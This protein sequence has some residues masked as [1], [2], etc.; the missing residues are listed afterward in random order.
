MAWKKSACGYIFA[1]KDIA[2]LVAGTKYCFF[3]S[4]TVKR[5]YGN[6]LLCWLMHVL[7]QFRNEMALKGECSVAFEN[8]VPPK[9]Y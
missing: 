4:K 8:N 3:F 1:H 9:P 5:D 7:R 6:I 2:L